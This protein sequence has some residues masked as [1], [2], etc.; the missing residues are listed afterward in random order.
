MVTAILGTQQM[1]ECDRSR[2]VEL[3]FDPDRHIDAKTVGNKW[4]LSQEEVTPTIEEGVQACE[5]EKTKTE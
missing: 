3:G 5:S 2:L 4:H 1:N